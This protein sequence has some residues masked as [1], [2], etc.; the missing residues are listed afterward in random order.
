AIGILC[1]VF[2]E[3]AKA[4]RKPFSVVS[5]DNLRENG[6]KL[7]RAVRTYLTKLSGDGWDE[8]LDFVL[9]DVSFPCSMVDRIV[10]ELTS[11][12]KLDIELASGVSHPE[13][14]ATEEFTQWVIEDRFVGGR[15][16]WERVFVDF[17]RDIKPFEEMKLRM[18]NATH[19]LLAYLGV[20]RGY[21]FV[22]QAVADPAINDL[23]RALLLEEVSP[24]LEKYHRKDRLAEYAERLLARF[25]NEKLPHRLQQI[26]ADGSVKISQRILPSISESLKESTLRSSLIT[27]LASWICFLHKRISAGQPLQDPKSTKLTALFEK[28]LEAFARKLVAEKDLFGDLTGNA[29]ITNEL[30]ARVL[31]LKA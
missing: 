6:R 25:A 28:D 22:H 21:E 17:V 27:A 1:L 11:E 23:A 4:G 29:L 18:L 2:R 20:L 16:S 9:S 24:L 13:L 10:P 26:A 14:L 3:R 15:P 31:S 19:S 12:V 5:C 30:T 7:E 8:A